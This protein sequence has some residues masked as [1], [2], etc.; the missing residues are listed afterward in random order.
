MP[1]A[2]TNRC[3]A[4]P[5]SGVTGR[6]N[7]P[8]AWRRRGKLLGAR[9]RESGETGRRA[10]LRIQWAKALGGSTPPSRTKQLKHLRRTPAA[11]RRFGTAVVPRIVPRHRSGAAAER[12]LSPHERRAHVVV[13]DDAVALEDADRLVPG[14]THRHALVNAGR[15]KVADRG[16]PEIVEDQRRLHDGLALAIDHWTPVA[17]HL[18]FRERGRDAG[19]G[20]RLAEV[21]GRRT[22]GK[23][24]ATPPSLRPPSCTC[25]PA[26]AGR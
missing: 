12:C 3:V 22:D 25:T 11:L 23:C 26:G 7:A 20:P 1:G 16:A 18:R 6:R 5:E 21:A 13:G 9:R 10:G 4:R 2:R 15:H 17:A 8:R 14:H 19:S 24:T